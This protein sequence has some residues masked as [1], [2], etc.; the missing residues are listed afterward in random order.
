[1]SELYISVDL[2]WKFGIQYTHV[3]NIAFVSKDAAIKM[4]LLL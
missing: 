4:I 2:E 1:M 3:N